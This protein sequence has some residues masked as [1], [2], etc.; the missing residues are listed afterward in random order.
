MIYGQIAR[1]LHRLANDHDGD[2]HN[3]C[4]PVKQ[5]QDELDHACD[6]EHGGTR[7]GTFVPGKR[8]KGMVSFNEIVTAVA[9]YVL[10]TDVLGDTTSYDRL[11]VTLAVLAAMDRIAELHENVGKL[12]GLEKAA[13]TIEIAR[14]HF[15]K[16][17]KFDAAYGCVIAGKKLEDDL[18]QAK[19]RLSFKEYA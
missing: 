5:A 15:D 4:I 2:S 3:R 18:E 11:Q 6:V 16:Q 8:N 10:T 13:G 17:G 7:L 12:K 1:W 9:G 14:C 19:K